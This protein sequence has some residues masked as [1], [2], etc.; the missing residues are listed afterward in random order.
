ML[1]R[2]TFLTVLALTACIPASADLF[3]VRHA[4]KKN[5]QMDKSTLSE[6]GLHRA[7]ALKRVLTDVPLQ[8][9]Y[10]T[11]YERTRQTASPAAVAHGL[12]PIETNSE[13]I[14]GLAKTLK[15]LPPSEDVLV[16]GHSDTIPDLL[17]E[18]GVSTKAAIGSQDFDNLFVV[19]LGSG[20]PS[21]HRLRY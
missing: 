10:C 5:P 20:V 4:E 1:C 11:E 8:A 2:Q 16:V 9:V 19:R 6:V 7:Q 21:Y 13:D 18:L 15:G 17:V 3:I 14:K 12:K